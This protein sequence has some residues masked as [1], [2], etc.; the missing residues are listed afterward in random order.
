LVKESC[1]YVSLE[2]ERTNGA[3]GDVSVQWKTIDDSAKSPADYIGGEGTL[4][5]KHGETLR[6][7]EIKIVDDAKPE[8]DECF[9]VEL[10]NPTDGAKLGRIFK[11]AITITNDDAFDSVVQRMMVLTTANLKSMEVHHETYRSQ[12]HDALT[13]NGG[14]VEEATSMD[15]FMHFLTF[16]W[17]IIFALIPPP[18]Y[19][20]GWLCFFA[21]LAAIGFLTAIIGDLAGIFGCLIGLPPTITA[22]TFVALGTSL[23]DLF[24]SKVAA[25][26]EKFADNAIGNVTGSN[27]VNVFLGLGLPWFLAAI[28]REIRGEKFE[29]E[30][31]ALGFSVIVY[32]AVAFI[33]LGLLFVR[34]VT[35]FFGRAE[36]GGPVGAKW[37][38]GV[39]LITL[40][41]IYIG[42][43]T[44][45]AYGVIKW[46]HDE[47]T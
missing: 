31:G 3:D 19:C 44:L 38:S 34:R 46:G 47:P 25:T 28:V 5:F 24:A 22:I 18:G 4:L 26:Q 43:S 17:K 1:D 10:F 36:L 30:S 15:Y 42:M 32:T 2:V 16:G 13:V 35:P 27:S 39:L 29:V 11:T 9:E 12:I 20:G 14:N 23:P 45:Q 33:A 6:T 37:A 21:S 40:W 8:K 41:F 7:I